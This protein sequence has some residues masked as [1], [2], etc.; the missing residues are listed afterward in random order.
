MFVGAKWH[1]RKGVPLAFL[2]DTATRPFASKVYN[3]VGCSNEAA[4]Y[5]RS[6][7]GVLFGSGMRARRSEVGRAHRAAP[8]R[9]YPD[10]QRRPGIYP[11]RI[12]HGQGWPDCERWQGVSRR[13]RAQTVTGI[14]GAFS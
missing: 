8:D 5:S 1:V 6:P 3:F 10:L 9:T 12:S 4:P 14:V 2:P 7:F 11:H 13:R